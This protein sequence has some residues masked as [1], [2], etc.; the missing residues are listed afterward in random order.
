MEPPLRGADSASPSPDLSVTAVQ[1]LNHLAQ[2]AEDFASALRHLRDQH[3]EPSYIASITEAV[4][5]LFGISTELR[6]LA[7]AFDQP[8]YYSS[9]YRVERD[10][11]LVYRS[12]DLTLQVALT[13]AHRT[14]DSSQWM[15][16]GDLD[17]RT[18][19][20]EGSDF[21]ERLSW[22][23]SYIQGLLDLLDGY[24]DERLM[25]LRN[26]VSNLLRSQQD[27]QSLGPSDRS[28]VEIPA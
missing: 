14:R 15:V 7:G 16:W 20:V 8:H 5:K 24:P 1:S 18:R 21:L 17:H 4:A 9:L 2:Q 19:A 26:H 10:V 12:F 22:Y 3:G 13:I 23:Q 6:R 28:G 11:Q 25:Q 27:D